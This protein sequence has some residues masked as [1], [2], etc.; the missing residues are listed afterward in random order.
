MG[1]VVCGGHCS[2]N[3]AVLRVVLFN[4]FFSFFST[5]VAVG[6]LAVDRIFIRGGISTSAGQG[7]KVGDWEKT[8]KLD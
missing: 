8:F 6:C 7:E 2:I 1:G 3:A 5:R 4:V